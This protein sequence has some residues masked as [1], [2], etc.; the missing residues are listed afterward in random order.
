MQPD[1]GAIIDKHFIGL[2]NVIWLLTD[3]AICDDVIHNGMAEWV[4]KKYSKS[5]GRTEII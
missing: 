5:S 1:A 4:Y 2:R 3:I